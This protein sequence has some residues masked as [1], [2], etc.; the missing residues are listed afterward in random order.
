MNKMIPSIKYLDATN[1]EGLKAIQEEMNK[2]VLPKP[3]SPV[4]PINVNVD[5]FCTQVRDQEATA[6]TMNQVLRT[7]QPT[8][9]QPVHRMYHR[10][11]AKNNKYRQEQRDRFQELFATHGKKWTSAKYAE[12]LGIPVSAINNWRRMVNRHQSLKYCSNRNAYRNLLSDQELLA[13]SNMLDNGDASMTVKDMKEELEKEFPDSPH[14]SLAT[15]DHALHGKRMVELVGRDYSLKI[16]SYRSPS[17]N[18]PENKELRVKVMAELN[19]YINLG[20]IWV[21]I[22]E[23]HWE[24]NSRRKRAWSKVGKKAF[25]T[26]IPQRTQFSSL[27]AIDDRGYVAA[28]LIVKGK[29][30]ADVFTK[31]FTKLVN[32]YRNEATVFFL[33]N[34]SIH[35]KETLK[36]LGDDD[37]HT[38]LFNAPYSEE[39]NPIEMFFNQWKAHTDTELKKWPGVDRFLQVLKEAVLAIPPDRIRSLF[40][41]VRNE[42]IPKVVRRENL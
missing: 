14:A 15:I 20:R 38:V 7:Q 19:Q 8:T 24:I 34:A 25:T 10:Q 35:D 32:Q 1:S 3:T 18:T 31:F 22:D 9:E 4:Q 21:S 28:C 2:I 27:T 23:T 41:H 16:G 42:V 5:A 29:V 12:V 37:K 13:L 30:N 33:D 39:L 6:Q 40:M 11:F 17:A 36:G 26:F